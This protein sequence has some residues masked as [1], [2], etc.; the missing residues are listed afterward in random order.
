MIP[1]RTI[2]ISINV[3]STIFAMYVSITAW[4]RRKN[5]GLMATFLS[6]SMA[7]TTIYAFGYTMELASNTLSQ[8]LF[9]VKIEHLGIEFIAPTWVLFTLFMTGRQKMLTPGKILS[10]FIIPLGMVFSVLTNRYHLNPQ[11]TANAPFPTLFYTR[12]Q[13]AW[14]GIGYIGFCLVFSLIL[15]TMMFLQAAPAFRKQAMIFA[16]GSL[17]PLLGMTITATNS[18]LY[19]LDL[20]PLSMSIS[21]IFFIIG[22]RHLQI[23]DIVPLARDVIFEGMGD[24]LLVFDNEARLVDFNPQTKKVFPEIGDVSVGLSVNKVFGND[25]P[26]TKLIREG[27][28]EV[29][30]LQREK[31]TYRCSMLPLYNLQKKCV[32][33]VVTMQ[34]YTEVEELVKQLSNL[35]TLDYLTGIYNRRHFYELAAKEVARAER[36]DKQLS[37]IL[38]DLDDFKLINDTLGHSAGDAVLKFIVTLIL[39][40]LR[41]YD[42]FGRFGGD[43]FLILLPETDITAAQALA[44]ELRIL[45]E[46]SAIP[47]EGQTIKITGSFG[48]AS[49]ILKQAAPFEDLVRRADKAVYEAKDSGRNCVC[50]DS[51]NIVVTHKN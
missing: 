20:A 46:K 25:S 38:F 26:L 34:D 39:E 36:L 16:L 11:L 23:L 9:W 42:I 40:R 48:V 10:F 30:K 50:I 28:K 45:L 27:S 37:L 13:L 47:F 4:S 41:S 12:G 6:L 3:L 31:S 14:I 2:L 17:F 49:V 35:A 22:F 43:E 1:V 24:G 7:A 5:A 18:S 44:E 8:I 21:G 33:K 29:I 51:T 15:F 32:G 19:N